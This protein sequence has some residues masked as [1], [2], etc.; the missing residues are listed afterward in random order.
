MA[1]GEVVGIGL[2]EAGADDE[3]AEGAVAEGSVGIP[4]VRGLGRVGR[5]MNDGKADLRAAGSDADD[6]VGGSLPVAANA[7]GGCGEGDG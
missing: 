1:F 5:E 4:L 3:A 6:G 7:G 2:R